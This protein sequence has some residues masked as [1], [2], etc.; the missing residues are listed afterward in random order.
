MGVQGNVWRLFAGSAVALVASMSAVAAS[1]QSAAQSAAADTNSGES[2]AQAF[3]SSEI[4]V[5]GTRVIRDGFSAPTPT[6]VIGMQEIGAKAPANIADFVNDLPSLAGSTTPRSNI[7]AVSAGA[8]GINALNLRNIGLNRTLVLLD[9]QRVGASTIT[10]QVDVNQIPQALVQRVDVVTGGA[11]ASWGSDAVAGV[12]N[13]VL[14]KEY[15]GLKGEAQGGI[16]TYGD[17]ASFKV[18]LTAGTSFADGR[19]H[20][21]V[22]GEI[23]HNKGIHGVGKRT[24]YNRTKVFFNPDYSKTNG[25]PELIV[26][27]NTGFAT[28]A[29][30]GIITS[31]P[32][33]GTYF[34]EGGVPSQ[35]DY[36]S[37]VSGQF[38]HGGQSAYT[39]FGDS[40]SL[41]PSTSRQGAFFRTSYDLADRVEAFFQL[42]YGR[43]TSSSDFSNLYHFGNLTIQPDNAFIPASIAS[44]ITAPFSLGTSNHDLGIAVINSERSSWRPVVGVR[45]QFDAT[46]TT[47]SWD[48][49][50]QKTIARSYIEAN[51][52]VTPHL[53]A[54]I[55][56]VYDPSGKIVC[57][58]SLTD[59]TNG[60][61]PYNVFGTNVNGQDVR[62]YVMGT[63]WG[64]TK[65]TQDVYAANLNGDPFSTWAGPVSLA[66][67]IEHRREAVSGSNDPLSTARAY[68][69]GNYNSSFGSFHVTEGYAEVVVPLASNQGFA[70]VLD[71][72]LAARATN[73]SLSGYV[74]TWKAG[75]VYKPV[76]DVTLRFTRS[77]DIRAPNLSELF[78]SNRT[79]TNSS[80]D[81]FRDNAPTTFFNITSGNLNLKPEKADSLGLGIVL[82]PRFLP[83]FAASV[84]YYNVDIKDAVGTIGAGATINQ[85]Y[86]GKTILCD[87]I[88]RNADGVITQVITQPINLAK[89]LARGL[90]FEAS[91]RTRLDEIASGLAG[92]LTIRALATRYIRNVTDNGISPAVDSVGR[93]NAGGSGAATL[94]YWS[95]FGSIGWDNQKWS[96]QATARG[97]SSGLLNTTYIECSTACPV[98]T[99]DNRTVDNN[100]LPGAVYFGLNMAAKVVP[101]GELFLSVDNVLNKNPAQTAYGPSIGGAPLSIS[102]SLYDT[103]GRRFRLGV[104]FSL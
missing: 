50:A 52:S 43:A 84:D 11:S 86:E 96:M 104:R 74:T 100:H 33:R 45:G 20:V 72:N 9:G 18:S 6:S 64:R 27:D 71:L 88:T 53:N 3:S 17:N 60:C 34:G 97:F 8:G 46:G 47:W 28:L 65:L 57:R 68:F 5:T 102:A 39:D 7:S 70:Q 23:A 38:M 42:S 99:T 36:G 75:V 95:Y 73:Y 29:P 19:G 59:P 13:F 66:L 56:A 80:Q 92:N 81:P 83:G 49:Y 90:D 40:T 76:D 44:G 103:L 26:R 48:A 15:E 35:L 4:I 12:V 94:P 37:I 14:D 85:C 91:Y 63:A 32:M 87:S 101:A 41:D 98:S 93:N 79:V 67:G 25:L 55:D 21:I 62:D 31:G 51:V 1:A 16:T 82:Q 10:G 2:S 58:S 24:W 77:R 22:N 69:A 89:Q 61:V 78:Q 54:A 30:G